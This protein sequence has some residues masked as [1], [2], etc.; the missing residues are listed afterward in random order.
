MCCN[1]MLKTKVLSIA[2]WVL[3][4]I[5]V[6]FLF[7]RRSTFMWDG[8]DPA[9]G[10]EVGGVIVDT[11]WGIMLIVMVGV[12]ALYWTCVYLLKQR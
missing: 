2:V 12:S 11:E 10:N 4:M 8:V 1:K 9:P 3:V 6:F 5:G 7:Y